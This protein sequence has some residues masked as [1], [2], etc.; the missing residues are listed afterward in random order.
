MKLSEEQER[1]FLK[2]IEEM[3]ELSLELIHAVNKPKKN[4]QSK[5]LSEIQDVETYIEKVKNTVN[6][7]L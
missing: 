7:S 4:N 6:T 2:L 3:Q 1:F 5:I